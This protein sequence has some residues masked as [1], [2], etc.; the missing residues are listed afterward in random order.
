MRKLAN[1]LSVQF[2][3]GQTF[4]TKKILK[5]ISDKLKTQESTIIQAE[6]MLE[7]IGNNA[8]ENTNDILEGSL[9]VAIITLQSKLESLRKHESQQNWVSQG[10]SSVAAV[11]K[12][13][14]KIEDYTF[15]VI[16]LLAKYIRASQAAFFI[17]EK[18]ETLKLS[19][20]YAYDKRKHSD[21][22][23]EIN[24]ENGLL[25]QCVTEK[26]F[27]H[28]TQLPKN[29]VKIASGLG[30]AIP[31]CA[32]M[33]PLV[34]R[35]Q[36]Y[37]VIEIASLKDFEPQHLEFIQKS[38]EEI[39]SEL[40]GLQ[41]QVHTKTLLAKAQEQANQLSSH[42]EELKQ[43]MEEMQATQEEMRRKEIALQEKL[44]E[45]EAER[46]KNLAILESCMDAVI[47]FNIDGTIEFCNHAGEEVLGYSRYELANH[48]I[49]KILNLHLSFKGEEPVLLS[50]NGNQIT[51]RSE[52]NTKDR[53]GEEL[54]L[55][56]TAT[57][58]KLREKSMFTLFAQ[59]ISVDLF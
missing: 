18:N 28:L 25:G 45:I 39:A 3:G 16:S 24:S 12:N 17:L 10:V 47:S 34:Y 59:K 30:E 40:A 44:E 2:L 33:V 5:S 58:I 31:K 54:S 42:E 52:V 9:G 36:V 50:N 15:H 56:L 1:Q 20:T 37:G 27:I 29:Y 41:I 53:S 49:Y 26:E 8:L 38:S 6:K 46:A 55:L 14:T 19:A 23:I 22:N 21:S 32:V 7:K 4:K 35:D 51:T 57:C 43:N 48:S 11:R 13:H